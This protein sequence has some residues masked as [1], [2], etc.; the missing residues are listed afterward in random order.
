MIDQDDSVFAWIVA[1][2]S[3]IDFVAGL[4][5]LLAG[6][7]FD[8][9][10]GVRGRIRRVFVAFAATSLAFAFK[11]VGLTRMGMVTFGLISL[12]Y[13]DLVVV[14]P[15]FGLVVLATSARGPVVSRSVRVLAAL[16]LIAAP[17]GWYATYWEPFNLKVEA[18]NVPLRPERSGKAPLR[19]AVLTDLQVRGVTDYER[20][21]VDRLLALK[22]DL[23]LLP[24]DI[25]QGSELTL[26]REFADLHALLTKLDAPFGVYFA[27][28]DVDDAPG[29]I[30]RLFAGTKVKLLVNDLIQIDAYDRH[31]TIGGVEL[32]YDSPAA[33]RLVE[34][35]E[36]LPG[37][38]DVRILLGHRPDVVFRLRESSRVDLVV[39]GHT[40]GGQIVIPGFGPPMTLSGVPRNVAAGGLH[41]LDGNRIYVSRGVGCERAQAPRI[42]FLCPPEVSILTLNGS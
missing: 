34:R 36:A 35:L 26:D 4:A 22:P 1:G 18:A 9:A 14:L 11:A 38:D 23:I 31:I 37:A 33:T 7:T 19:I 15:L 30:E 3:L 41:V 32:R 28:G 10:I 24:G 42:R 17:V 2:S 5:I 16:S 29:R 27:P 25:F 12:V 21:A 13:V 39:S 20:G 8:D 40:H 6:P